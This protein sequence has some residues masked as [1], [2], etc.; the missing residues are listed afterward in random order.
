MPVQLTPEQAA[1]VDHAADRHARVLAG[2]GT[3]KSSTV[4][5]LASRLKQGGTRGVRLVTF[6]RA[7]S[8]EL[9]AKVLAEGAE[10]L[11]P[12]TIHS[13]AISILLSNPGSAGMPN[14][15][16]CWMTGSGKNLLARSSVVS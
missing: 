6:T 3:G 15:S 16:E 1:V 8:G 14:H 2:P 10:E 13:F 9:A 11:S 12:S 4:I 7:A 5:S